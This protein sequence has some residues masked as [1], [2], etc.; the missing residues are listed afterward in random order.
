VTGR[1]TRIVLGDPLATLPVFY[2]DLPTDAPPVRNEVP[3]ADGCA[4]ADAVTPDAAPAIAST[5]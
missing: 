3:S 2:G 4:V 1:R 5:P